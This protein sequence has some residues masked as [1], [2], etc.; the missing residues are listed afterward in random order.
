MICHKVTYA[1]LKH[2]DTFQD[3]VK[4]DVNAAGSTDGR[5]VFPGEALKNILNLNSKLPAAFLSVCN[6][7]FQ[8]V[9]ARSNYSEYILCDVI[10]QVTLWK[11]KPTMGGHLLRKDSPFRYIFN[12]R[13]RDGSNYFA[14]NY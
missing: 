11:Y 13:L 6:S 14:K 3:L 5:I 2:D 1:L 4:S 10:S 9:A 8:A 12:Q 7:F